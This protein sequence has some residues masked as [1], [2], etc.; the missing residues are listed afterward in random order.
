MVVVL[1]EI[2]VQPG[3]AERFSDVCIEALRHVAGVPACRSARL[4]RSLGDP[5]RFLLITEWESGEA[6]L[7]DFYATE[8]FVR[9]RAA[10][11]PFL[12]EPPRIEQLVEIVA[13]SP[14]RTS[15]PEA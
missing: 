2:L 5:G 1:A 14:A 11:G 6:L 10:V 9:W 7:D 12:L 3:D 8:N 13:R 15:P 4:T